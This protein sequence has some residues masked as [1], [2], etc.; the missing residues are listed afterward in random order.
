MLRAFGALLTLRDAAYAHR[1]STENRARSLIMK[2]LTLLACFVVVG[3]MV[4]PASAQPRTGE[5][6]ITIGGNSSDWN[7]LVSGG[8]DGYTILGGAGPWFFYPSANPQQDP[9]G[10]LNPTPGWHNQWWYDHPYDPNRYKVVD[11]SFMYGRWIDKQNPG[12]AEIWINFSTPNWSNPDA[13]PLTNLDP[14]NGLQWVDRV[15]VDSLTIW[16]DVPVAWGSHYDLRDYG[17]NYNPEWVSIDV[18]GYNFLLAQGVIV[19]NCVP[20]PL[21]LSLLAASA[22]LGVLRRK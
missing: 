22:M 2:T 14:N 15:K 18:V 5:F 19:H 13:P 10:N 12:Y 4:V 11:V 9:W 1:R 3:L 7:D 6:Y 20:E 17:V 21:T 16:N 8:G